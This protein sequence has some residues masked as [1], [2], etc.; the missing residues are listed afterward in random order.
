MLSIL[1]PI[2]NYNAYPLVKELHSQC[3]EDFDLRFCIDDASNEYESTTNSIY[4]KLHL[5]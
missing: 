2:Y 4:I 1:I 5:Y 3:L